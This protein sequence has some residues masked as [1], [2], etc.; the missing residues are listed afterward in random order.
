MENKTTKHL[1]EWGK[2]IESYLALMCNRRVWR[3]EDSQVSIVATWMR[4][5]AM[6]SKQTQAIDSTIET[7]HGC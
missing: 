6:G 4:V 2:A 3:D 5:S 7:E 1:T